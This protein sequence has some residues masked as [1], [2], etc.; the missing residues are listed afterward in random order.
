MLFGGRRG[1]VL[2][3]QFEEHGQFQPGCL[4]VFVSCRSEMVRGPTNCKFAGYVN[5]VRLFVP[6]GFCDVSINSAYTFMVY[7]GID[8]WF[9][10][11]L[12][13]A[14]CPNRGCGFDRSKLA[15][16]LVVMNSSI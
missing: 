14:L 7:A 13:T 11:T 5:V 6:V 12:S 2:G 4:C 10:V 8:E 1:A 3:A 9:D 16:N 15:E